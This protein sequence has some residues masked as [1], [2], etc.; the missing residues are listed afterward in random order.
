MVRQPL[1]KA[2]APVTA[3]R[4]QLILL[5]L[6]TALGCA[7]VAYRLAARISRPIE[8]LALAARM[9]EDRAGT[10][11]YPGDE[12][13]SEIKQLNHSFQS[14]TASLLERERELSQLNTSLEQLVAERTQA[15]HRAN[16]ELENL[17]IHDALTG[18]YNR[19]RFDEKLLEYVQLFHRTGRTFALLLIDADHFK[20]VNDQHGHQAGDAVLQQLAQVISGNV[21]ITDFVARYGGEEFVVLLPEPQDRQE[22]RVVAEKIRV[23]VSQSP[24]PAVGQ[25]TVSLGMGFS[26][27]GDAR[28]TDIVQRADRALYQA[29]QQGRNQVVLAAENT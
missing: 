18:L 9:I 7:L 25:I 15:L 16:Q 26:S 11:V 2:L 28:E 12:H 27:L 3:L 14:M 13:A 4:R 21:R 29:K 20:N 10:P 8:Q 1:D 23:A 6:L 24:F 17:A 19:R 22:G 5:G